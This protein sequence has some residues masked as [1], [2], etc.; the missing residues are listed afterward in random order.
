MDETMK[1]KKLHILIIMFGCVLSG[2]TQTLEQAKELFKNGAFAQAKTIFAQHIKSKPKDANL[3]QWY[4]VCLYETGDRAI[5]EKHL[6]IAA[7]KSIPEAFRYL[8]EYYFSNYR[9]DEAI[10]QWNKYITLPLV[11]TEY[12]EM[13]KKKITKAETASR[14]LKGVVKVEII[15]S[16]IVNKEDFLQYYKLSPEC[17]SLKKFDTYFRSQSG[18]FASVYEN[19]KK[20][21]IYFASK[22]GKDDFDIFSSDKLID[23]WGEKN[24]LASPVNSPNNE[25]FPYLLSDGTTL[26]FASDGEGSMGGY[27]IFAT[28]LN[29]SDNSFL[30]PENV[31]MPFNSTANDYMLAIDEQLKIG[32]FAS[33]RNLPSEKVAIYIFIPREEKVVYENL[34]PSQLISLAMLKSIRESWQSDQKSYKTILQS[35]NNSTEATSD[36]EVAKN[37]FIFVLD[38]NRILKSLSDCKNAESAK[39]LNQWLSTKS[40]LEAL[41]DILD[42]LRREYQNANEKEKKRISEII[43]TKEKES[44]EFQQKLWDLEF[45]FREMEKNINN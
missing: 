26:Y 45:R 14:L 35:I 30:T 12:I 22:N 33:D 18:N 27:D 34:P 38:D 36:Q 5:A 24:R 39:L 21:R 13:Y 19:E 7:Q 9:F 1:I 8:G 32:W 10:N 23:T 15:D 37:D 43:L 20:D 6:L 4:G 16:L 44:D 17:G 11:S 29:L 3:N 31:G 42:K 41:S 25:N 40:Q 2:Y 28:R